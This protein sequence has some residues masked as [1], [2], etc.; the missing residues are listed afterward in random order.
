MRRVGE[1]QDTLNHEETEGIYLR[2][3]ELLN[4][5]GAQP[6]DSPRRREELAWVQNKLGFNYRIDG[7]IEEAARHFTQAMEIYRARDRVP[8]ST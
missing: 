8:R 4:D 6:F 5:V 3:I 1:I 2:A 7:R